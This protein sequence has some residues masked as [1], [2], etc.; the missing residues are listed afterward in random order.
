MG[1]LWRFEMPNRD[2]L[3]LQL[4]RLNNL[5]QRSLTLHAYTA[6]IHHHTSSLKRSNTERPRSV[7]S[8]SPIR[9]EPTNQIVSLVEALATARK[10]IDTQSTRMRDLE[11]MLQK[12]RQARELAEEVAKRVVQSYEMKTNGHHKAIAGGSLKAEAFERPAESGSRTK[13]GGDLEKSKIIDTTSISDSTLLLEQRL[14]SMLGEMAQMKEQMQNFK[15]RAETAESERDVDR[16]T[17]VEMVE[18]IRADEAARALSSAEHTRL[19]LRKSANGFVARN[20]LG[21]M[22]QKAGLT[23]GS[24]VAS[25]GEG[26]QVRQLSEALSRLPGDRDPFL[27]Q[28]TPYASMLGVVLLGMGLM[29]YMN[30]W[31]PPR[32][33]R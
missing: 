7:P 14:E 2:S 25:K 30:G 27:Y 23:N 17:L 16:K 10:E 21:P 26:D 15:K 20:P 33:D 22:L 5:F 32:V 9:Q 1:A 18:K 13:P 29:A 19:P 6:S 11:E 12:E 24:V 31:Q 3:I 28:A 4:L 8:T